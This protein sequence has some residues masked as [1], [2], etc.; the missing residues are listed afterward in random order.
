MASVTTFEE[1]RA[2]ELL[3]LVHRVLETRPR[4][5]R[6]FRARARTS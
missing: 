3:A 4:P 6:I 2:V 5:T 1:R